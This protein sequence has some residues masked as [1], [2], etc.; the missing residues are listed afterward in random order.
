[1]IDSFPVNYYATDILMVS[2]NNNNNTAILLVP[3]QSHLYDRDNGG[4]WQSVDGG[5][6]F[7]KVDDTPTFALTELD[8]RGILATHARSSERSISLSVDGGK[9]FVDLGH[10]PWD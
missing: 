1:M 7:L 10:L 4:I 8:N 2:N 9:T 3:A 5:A 6:T